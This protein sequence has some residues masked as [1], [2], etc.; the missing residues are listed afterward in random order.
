MKSFLMVP[1]IAAALF[2]CSDTASAQ[3][4]DNYYSNRSYS[5]QPTYRS[6]YSN[7]G[8]YYQPQRYQRRYYRPRY[9]NVGRRYYRRGYCY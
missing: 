8:S 4:Y 5:Y 1:L 9:R 7:R 6:R 2:V 3:C